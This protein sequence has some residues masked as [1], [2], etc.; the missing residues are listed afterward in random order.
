[1]SV[2]SITDS[3]VT[4]EI[5]AAPVSVE[6]LRPQTEHERVISTID[7]TLGLI[8]EANDI[9]ALRLPVKSYDISIIVPVYNERETLPKVLQRIEEVMPV[10]TEII[11]VDDGSTDGTSEWLKQL[12]EKAGLTVLCRRKNHGKGSA[13]RLAIRHSQGHVVAIQDADLEYDPADLL[14]VIWPILDGD[15]EVVYGSRYLGES[16]DGSFTHRLGNW[17]LTTASNL[18]TGLRLTDMETC[19]KAFDGDLLRSISLRECRFGFEPEITA[20]IAARDSI[21]LEVPTG[22]DSRGY[23]EGKKIGWRDAVSA[24]G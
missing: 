22:Y 14:R 10:A 24:L 12:P 19:H 18:L 6:E 20:K 11:V 16:G 8:A 1:M 2:D 15:A 9:A 21:I 4:D 17:A 13:V 5:Y 3:N 7:Q 23:D